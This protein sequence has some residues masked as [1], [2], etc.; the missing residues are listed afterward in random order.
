[1]FGMCCDKNVMIFARRKC[2]VVKKIIVGKN[3]KKNGYSKTRKRIRRTWWKRCIY[4]QLDNWWFSKRERKKKRKRKIE[5][6][7][8]RERVERE[9]R[10][11]LTLFPWPC[12]VSRMHSGAPTCLSTQEEGC[13]QSMGDAT[14]LDWQFGKPSETTRRKFLMTNKM[15]LANSKQEQIASAKSIHLKY[16]CDLDIKMTRLNIIILQNKMSRPSQDVVHYALLTSLSGQGKN[17]SNCAF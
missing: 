3:K 1:M 16:V 7:R 12:N 14:F 17:I 5:R 13:P 11:E 8:W 2:V 4:E 6:E 9:E 15:T 10:E